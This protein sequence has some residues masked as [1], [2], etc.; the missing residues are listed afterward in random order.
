TIGRVQRWAGGR[1]LAHIEQALRR[2]RPGQIAT[3][4]AGR[5]G[6][7][8]SQLKPSGPVYTTLAEITLKAVA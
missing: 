2:A 6:L 3:F 5:A 7:I 1:D 8:R 4:Q